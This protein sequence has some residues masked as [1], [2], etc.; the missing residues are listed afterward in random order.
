[1]WQGRILEVVGQLFVGDGVASLVAPIGHMRLWQDAIPAP[2]WRSFVGWFRD[3]PAATRA[4]GVLNV[5]V[6]VWMC[7]R[8]SEE[9]R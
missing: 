2:W 3:R 4:V 9:L 6:G 5:A 1:M 8:A 7:L